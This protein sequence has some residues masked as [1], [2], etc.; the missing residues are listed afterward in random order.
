MLDRL[1]DVGELGITRPYRIGRRWDTLLNIVVEVQARSGTYFLKVARTGGR[2]SAEFARTRTL[3]AA[4]ERS[5][6]DRFACVEAVAY[7]DSPETLLVRGV[8]GSAFQDLIVATCSWSARAPLEPTLT[9]AEEVGRWLKQLEDASRGA[10]PAT[11]VWKGLGAEVVVASKNI[12]VNRPSRLARNLLHVCS[13]IIDDVLS[14]ASELEVYLA[15][16]DFHPGNLFITSD[17]ERRVSVIDC[18]LSTAH[19]LG[20]DALLM[21]FHLMMDYS[22]RTYNPWRIARVRAAFKRGYGRQLLSGSANVRAISAAIVMHS[23]VYL[24]TSDRASF[25]RRVAVELDLR[26]ARRWLRQ[27]AGAA[28]SAAPTRP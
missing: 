15:H 20:Y 22:L 17:R 4:L 12:L 18:R 21:D 11:L 9:A 23:I 13:R 16:R 3:R 7:F 1:A 26:R 28:L 19:F 24:T 10:S 5:P 14:Q 2:L 27:F 6:V 8:P 25:P